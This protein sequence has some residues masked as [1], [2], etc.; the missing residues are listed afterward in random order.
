MV[1]ARALTLGVSLSG[2]LAGPVVPH[3][4]A[5]S[6]VDDGLIETTCSDELYR[7]PDATFAVLAADA[8]GFVA[9]DGEEFPCDLDDHA[10][11]CPTRR[12]I[13]LPITGDTVLTWSVGIEGA[14]TDARRMH[15]EQTFKITCAGS[16]CS[17]DQ[18]V[19]GYA[20]PC[21]YRVG[22]HATAGL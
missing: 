8:N 1:P 16:L 17:L 22:F 13:E 6:Y 21:E 4:G 20:L 5:W 18:A 15:G 12:K 9:S 11:T 10:F 14:F 2:C 19:L 3:V 7:D